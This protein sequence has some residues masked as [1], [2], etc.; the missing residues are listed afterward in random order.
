MEDFGK[1]KCISLIN[2][3]ISVCQ[4]VEKLTMETLQI[5][6]MVTGEG[7]WMVVTRWKATY[8]VNSLHHP[9]QGQ[10]KTGGGSWVLSDDCLMVKM[11]A[12]NVRILV[13]CC[14]T[15][16]NKDPK[17]HHVCQYVVPRML[18]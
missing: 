5:A 6:W 10:C 14:H 13:S 18:M 2:T 1:A 15:I 9:E 3:L 7:S 12:E 17:M 8:T 4:W 16:F 11:T